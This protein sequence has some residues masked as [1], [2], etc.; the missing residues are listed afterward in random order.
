MAIPLNLSFGAVTPDATGKDGQREPQFSTPMAS[1]KYTSFQ[2]F[3]AGADLTK[4]VDYFGQNYNSNKG[5]GF[6]LLG[7]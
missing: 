4:S 2:S 6:N 7:Q 5:S 3:R 1:H